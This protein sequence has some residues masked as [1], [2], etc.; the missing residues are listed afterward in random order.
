[1]KHMILSNKWFS[2]GLVCAIVLLP[3]CGCVETLSLLTVPVTA[4]QCGTMAYQSFER[5]E[6]RATVVSGVT[7]K[8]LQKIKHIAILLGPE[9]DVP[10]AEEIGDL[11]AVVGDNLNIQLKKIGLR[12]CD[13][14]KLEKSTL[15]NLAKTG[16]SMSDIVQAGRS[17][18]VHAIVTGNVTG[19][20]RRSFGMLGVG[21]MN[22]IVQSASMKIIGVERA[23][24]LIIITAN[25]KVG[26]N[27]EAV[28]KGIATALKEKLV[29]PQSDVVAACSQRFLNR[30]M[31]PVCAERFQG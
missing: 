16:Y 14:S 13:G 28:A 9:C 17:L 31:R 30:G 4:I 2:G 1:M 24:T 12:V 29:N 21:R 15:R 25:Y 27:P 19:A 8:E 7:E 22:T 18:G 6:I 20:Q 3:L 23:D 11:K 10:L 5:V 26:Q